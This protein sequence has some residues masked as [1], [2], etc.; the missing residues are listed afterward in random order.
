MSKN[1]P[2]HTKELKGIIKKFGYWSEE[3]YNYN[4]LLLDNLGIDYQMKIDNNAK[5]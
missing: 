1:A 3:V 2:K 4:N 5:R